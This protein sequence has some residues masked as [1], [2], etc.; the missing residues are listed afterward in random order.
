M[1]TKTNTKSR[2]RPNTTKRHAKHHT[3]SKHYL[4]VYWPY[5]PMLLIV[6]VGLFFGSGRQV[7]SHDVLSYATEISSE[8]LLD[9]TNDERKN[10]GG[11][12]LSINPELS[13]AAQDKAN[14]MA[15]RNYWSHYTPE[16]KAPWVFI[17]KSGYSYTK[18]GENLAYGF[19]TSSETIAGWMNSQTHRENMLDTAFSDV[20]FGFANSA[21]YNNAGNETIVVAMYGQPA[22]GSAAVLPTT[23]GSDDTTAFNS[24]SAQ[25]EPAVQPVT[26]LQ[27]VMGGSAPWAT[28]VV[29]VISGGMIFLL[30]IRH[31]LAFKRVFVHGEQFFLKH[32]VLD[33]AVVS[34]VMAGYVL[35]QTTGLI[36]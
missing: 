30:I 26:M 13:A 3:V 20:G 9:A 23:S 19:L 35:S 15:K 17:D 2:T 11:P 16:G 28:F 36:R 29:G 33:V 24:A 31:G 18:A 4:K 25:A 7:T 22:D 10:S 12:T 34:F 5:V 8:K 1:P 6:A 21:Q 27:N 14:D 32:P